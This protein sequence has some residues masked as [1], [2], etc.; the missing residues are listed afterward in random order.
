M[1]RYVPQHVWHNEKPYMATPDVDLVEMADSAVARGD[2]DVAE[3]D[4]HVVL[5]CK[6][7]IRQQEHTL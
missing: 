2:C 3:L 5:S 1:N 4:I 7:R 6:G